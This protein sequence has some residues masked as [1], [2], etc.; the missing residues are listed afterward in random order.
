MSSAD[1]WGAAGEVQ[2]TLWLKPV[3]F[4]VFSFVFFFFSQA[5][6][7]HFVLQTNLYVLKRIELPCF[8]MEPSRPLS[9]KRC[10]QHPFTSQTHTDNKLS[11]VSL[12]FA[13]STKTCLTRS[14]TARRANVSEGRR[15][16][17]KYTRLRFCFL[18][19]PP[20]VCAV[21]DHVE[22]TSVW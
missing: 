6:D 15:M 14:T 11:S 9:H 4:F 8:S 18:L 21:V 5:A 3:V 12:S 10:S 22:C 16:N 13:L 2:Q 19:F 17:G 1:V 20:P 7:P